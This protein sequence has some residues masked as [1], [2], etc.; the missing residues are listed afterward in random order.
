[1]GCPFIKQFQWRKQ[2]L[3][4]PPPIPLHGLSQAIAIAEQTH[5][6][7]IDHDVLTLQHQRNACCVHATRSYERHS[8]KLSK[9]LAPATLHLLDF[10]GESDSH[11][12]PCTIASALEL[13]EREICD[14]GLPSIVRLQHVAWCEL[15][16][17][18]HQA[19]W[20]LLRAGVESQ[21]VG[22]YLLHL[23]GVANTH[24]DEQAG[25]CHLPAMLPSCR[26]RQHDGALDLREQLGCDIPHE[27]R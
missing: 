24:G 3:R 16:P 6:F 17:S 12:P 13:E 15:V 22:E 2:G 1:M 21:R 11:G 8:Q 18:H 19:P 10:G 5:H 4:E 27:A 20:S 26:Q 9:H 25:V 14:H 23:C 7:G